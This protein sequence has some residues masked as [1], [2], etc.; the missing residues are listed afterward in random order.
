MKMRDRPTD[1]PTDRPTDRPTDDV[2]NRA[3]IVHNANRQLKKHICDYIGA[4]LP[5][6]LQNKFCGSYHPYIL[7]MMDK[8]IEIKSLGR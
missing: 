1:Q 4:K 5:C 3:K 8:K 6:R 2:E 7:L